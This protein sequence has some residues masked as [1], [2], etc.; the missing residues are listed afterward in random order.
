M[1]FDLLALAISFSVIFVIYVIYNLYQKVQTLNAINQAL[2]ETNII[3]NKDLDNVNHSFEQIAN[4]H[5]N[6]I[7]DLEKEVIKSNHLETLYE[8]LN[9]KIKIQ[10]S[11]IENKH[12]LEIKKARKESVEKSRAVIRG[13]ATEHLAPYIIDDINPKDCRFMG[14][15]IDYVVFDGL[16]DVTDK[17]TKDVKEVIFVDIKTGKSN[18]TTVQRRIRDA[19]KDGRVS[20]RVV[21]PDEKEKENDNKSIL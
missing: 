5:E 15:P 1:Y 4:A 11:E 19:I 12:K 18:L 13:Q 16:S 20:F 10:I 8:E 21:N 9:K 14:N 3:I 2:L 17:V 6:I 7:V